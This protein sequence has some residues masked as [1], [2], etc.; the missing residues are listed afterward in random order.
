M[1]APIEPFRLTG[2]VIAE[3]DLGHPAASQQAFDTLIAKHADGYAYQIAEAY[4]WRGESDHAFA[5]LKRACAQRDAGLQ[6]L[7]Y[8]PMLRA[9]RNDSRY[10]ALLKKLGLPE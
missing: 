6:R 2:V 7:K 1:R 8:D 9:L 4:A 5:W 10:Q 3:H